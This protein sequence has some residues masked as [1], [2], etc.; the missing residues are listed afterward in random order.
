[1]R[2][3]AEHPVCEYCG[4]R[5]KQEQLALATVDLSDEDL[6]MELRNRKRIGRIVGQHVAPAHDVLQGIPE[7]YQVERALMGAAADL[8]QLHQSGQRMP[9]F[10]VETGRFTHRGDPLG[11]D[12]C[13][14]VVLNYIKDCK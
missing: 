12:R 10:K 6:L 8:F 14:R 5:N 3:A 13:V 9:G 2:H 11:R 1:M 4:D 7:D